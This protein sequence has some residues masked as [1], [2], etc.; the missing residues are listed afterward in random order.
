MAVTQILPV[1]DQ[2]FT[3]DSQL[4]RALPVITL[5][6]RGGL[7]GDK[8]IGYVTG[9]TRTHTRTVERLHQLEPFSTEAGGFQTLAKTGNDYFPGE[10]IELVPG[11][12]GEETVALT[13]YALYTSTLF[14][15]FMRAGGAG[16]A[17]NQTPVDVN[18]PELESRYTSLLQQV[19]PVNVYEYYV[20][21]ITKKVLWGII[22]YDGWF[23][24][25]GRR[26]TVGTDTVI[27]EEATIAITRSRPFEVQAQA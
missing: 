7:M 23:T 14:E 15:A 10:A 11:I 16:D 27:M 6:I 19:R 2:A 1:T 26:I 24:D 12:L 4:T 3:A 9:I 17:N 25:M 8:V 22:Y 5:A 21:P 18:N 13:R 20:S